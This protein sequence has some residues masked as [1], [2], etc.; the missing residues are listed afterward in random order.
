MR[1]RLRCCR[2]GLR[3]PPG[4]PGFLDS[5]AGREQCTCSPVFSGRRGSS[6]LGSL[7]VFWRGKKVLSPTV[8]WSTEDLDLGPRLL[9]WRTKPLTDLSG[10]SCYVR[11][12]RLDEPDV[13]NTVRWVLQFGRKMTGI[14]TEEVAVSMESDEQYSQLDLVDLD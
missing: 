7:S 8:S 6:S 3:L 14:Q 5:G 9:L 10:T 2:S 1:D 13:G 12:W 11:G 4:L